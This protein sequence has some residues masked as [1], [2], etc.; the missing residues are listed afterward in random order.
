MIGLFALLGFMSPAL[1]DIAPPTPSPSTEAAERALDAQTQEVARSLRCPVCQGLSIA[2]SSTPTALQWK[3]RIREL[4]AEGKTPD[5]VR[6]F[7]V[8]RDGEWVLLEPQVRGNLVFWLGPVV[9]GGLGLAWVAA[10]AAK[11]RKEP[12]ALPSDVGALPKDKYEER[13]LAELEE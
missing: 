4:L 8:E 12:E 6:A 11:W 9:M 2:E 3:G 5:E 10:V 1:A 7:F 13:L